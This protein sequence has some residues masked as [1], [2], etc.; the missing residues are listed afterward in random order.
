MTKSTYDPCLLYKSEPLGIIDLQINDT[1][2]LAKD[3]F[4]IIEEV[5]IKTANIITKKCIYLT[6]KTPI[7]FNGTLIQLAL[8]VDIILS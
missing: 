1:L 6:L 7:K 3:A 2:M 4:A 8:S 5:T